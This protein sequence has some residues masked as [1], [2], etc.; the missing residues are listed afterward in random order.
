[1]LADVQSEVVDIQREIDRLNNPL[2]ETTKVA[3]TEPTIM[4]S[5][6]KEE[7]PIKMEAIKPPTI[8][9]VK[10][11]S[12]TSNGLI[13]G[14]NT[15]LE[16]ETTRTSVSDSQSQADIKSEN[17]WNDEWNDW[18]DLDVRPKPT[19]NRFEGAQSSSSSSNSNNSNNSKPPKMK[20]EEEFDIESEILPNFILNKKCSTASNNSNMNTRATED[21]CKDIKGIVS[22]TAVHPEKIEVKSQRNY[23]EW[24]SIQKE[25]A[26]IE[27]PTIAPA[28]SD[29]EKREEKLSELMRSSPLGNDLDELFSANSHHMAATVGKLDVV[30]GREDNSGVGKEGMTKKEWNPAEDRSLISNIMQHSCENSG[31]GLASGN[32]GQMIDRRVSITAPAVTATTYFGLSMDS[33]NHSND[34]DNWLDNSFEFALNGTTHMQGSNQTT[35]IGSKRTWNNGVGVG[36]GGQLMNDQEMAGESSSM[37]G[38]MDDYY[39]KKMCYNNGE[40]DF[41]HLMMDNSVGGEGGSGGPVEMG[42]AVGSQNQSQSQQQSQQ[43]HQQPQSHINLDQMDTDD[44]INRQVQNA[45]DSI[46][47]LQGSDSPDYQ[48]SLDQTMG[49]LL[50]DSSSGGNAIMGNG[51]SGN[52]GTVKEDNHHM[53]GI[54]VQSGMLEQQQSN[55]FNDHMLGATANG[56]GLRLAQDNNS[57]TNSTSSQS[58][59]SSISSHSSGNNNTMVRNGPMG[60]VDS[61]GLTGTD[62]TGGPGDS[63][64]IKSVLTS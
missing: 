11:S 7:E 52:G 64:S 37:N 6:K 56:G 41:N 21:G 3:V 45:I 60:F 33:L 59:L 29:S 53:A 27:T 54:L 49:A 20:K 43:Q 36:G 46:L 34:H 44:D 32:N 12:T 28:A 62:G 42:M 50:V 35:A 2:E 17:Q 31:L 10:S 39:A 13:N 16:D 40:Y 57:P 4:E 51:E 9:A 18:D 47:N 5:V 1:M 8:E 30:V 25:L 26:S 15:A 24:L 55:S 61:L 48:Y 23:E 63:D 14:Q 38:V 58:L 19:V 22:M